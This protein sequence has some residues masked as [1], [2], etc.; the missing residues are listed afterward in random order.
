MHEE[1]YEV[2]RSA[3]GE[4]IFRDARGREIPD[5]PA[6]AGLPEDPYERIRAANEAAGL[7]I[8]ARTALPSWTGDR[9]DLGWAISVLHPLAAA[10]VLA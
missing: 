2:E 6:S 9:L 4:L 3:D 10:P 1:G 8:H 5:V 7:E